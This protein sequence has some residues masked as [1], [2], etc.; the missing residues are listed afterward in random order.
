[1]PQAFAGIEMNRVM[2]DRVARNFFSLLV[3]QGG[4]Y[5]L[6][7]ILV[8]YLIRTLGLGLFG[9]W[10]F[11][12]GFVIV[13]RTLV[14]Y[15][16]DLTATRQVAVNRGRPK[17]LSDIYVSVLLLRL[18][19]WILCFLV[20]LATSYAFEEIQ[21]VATLILLAMLI[22]VGEI[23]FP[24]WLFQGMETMGAI[25][26]IRLLLK[27]ANVGLVL[28]FVKSPDHVVL[29][30]IL[31]ALTTLVAGIIATALAWRRFRLVWR[32]PQISQLHHQ[33]RE[34]AA[35]F[36][37]LTAV[38][39]YTTLNVIVLGFIS[40]SVAVAQYSIAE[41]I[42]SA[43]RGLLGPFVQ[44]VF[45]AMAAAHDRAQEIFNS[46]S[47]RITFNLCIILAF[48]AGT[49]LMTADWL[50][51]LIV[52]EADETAVQCLQVFA[53]SLLFALG[54]FLSPMLVVRHQ[55]AVLMR[56]T[57]TS[58]VIGLLVVWPL[59]LKLGALGATLSFLFVQ[60]FNVTALLIVSRQS[61]LSRKEAKVNSG[62]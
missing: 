10:M 36:V 61:A 9:E 5:L 12:L 62:L 45:P 1:V 26:Q 21:Q 31:E 25:T 39:L 60:I 40:G 50:I 23:L 19:I 8:P 43:I 48:S 3:L 54:S 46:T 16:F 33:L 34:G 57:I 51:I 59:V 30:P 56:I 15:G 27:A 20:I 38:H 18:S 53:V 52:G 11:A 58:G 2:T 37:S 29:V 28:L 55:A 47:R 7:L 49:L 4:N 6:P 14:S 24:V 42:Y 44:A 35:V 22:L 32:R 17:L 41:K 13:A